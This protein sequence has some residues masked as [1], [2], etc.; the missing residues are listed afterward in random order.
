M[1]HPEFTPEQASF[2]ADKIINKL[3]MPMYMI[4]E[5]IKT[6]EIKVKWLEPAMVQ[7]QAIVNLIREIG[8]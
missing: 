5:G 1:K 4:D 8:G 2:L 7:L 3:V 6:G